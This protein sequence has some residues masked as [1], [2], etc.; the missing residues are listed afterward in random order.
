MHGF[1]SCFTPLNGVLFTFQS[2]YYT[3]SVA[4]EYL[5]LGGGPPRFIRASARLVLLENSARRPSRFAYGAIT[6]FGSTFQEIPLR[7]DLFTPSGI[8]SPHAALAT[9]GAQRLRA[10]MHRV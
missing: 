6:L 3:L 2:P 9:P 10:C 7:D 8:R 5:A 4:K 1:R